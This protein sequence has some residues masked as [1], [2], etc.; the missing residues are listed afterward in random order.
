MTLYITS[1]A[2]RNHLDISVYA[3]LDLPSRIP[4]VRCRRAELCCC[5]L[6]SRVGRTARLCQV[7]LVLRMQQ[8]FHCAI[9]DYRWSLWQVS[10]CSQIFQACSKAH[11]QG[12]LQQSLAVAISISTLRGRQSFRWL[13]LLGSSLS[14]ALSPKM[15]LACYTKIL[16]DLSAMRSSDS[17]E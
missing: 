12:C 13:A 1:F 4:L 7:L 3:C 5:G 8:M 15:S 9:L 11:F 17:L 16:W 10:S 14:S 2:M 6:R